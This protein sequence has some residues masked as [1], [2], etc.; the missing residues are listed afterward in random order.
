MNGLD[1]VNLFNGNLTVTVP[2]GPRYHV[3]GALSYGLTLVYSG[4]AWEFLDGYTS[5]T[6]S[7]TPG[8]NI[9]VANRRSNA[10]VGWTLS[11]GRLFPRNQYPVQESAL[12]QYETPDG[13][14]HEF[15][16]TV[17]TPGNV[18][19]DVLQWTDDGT[20]LRLKKEADGSRLVEFPD[21]TVQTFRWLDAYAP[22]TWGD[23]TGPNGSW[24]LTR[25]SDAFGNQVTI[26]YRTE[27]VYPEVWVI[28][29]GLRQQSVYFGETIAQDDRLVLDH[30]VLSA[31]GGQ[32]TQWDFSYQIRQIG[33]GN[34]QSTSTSNYTHTVSTMPLLTAITAPAAVAGAPRQTYSMLDPQG[35]PYYRVATDA[36]LSNAHLQGMQLPTKGWLEWSYKTYVFAGSSD[37]RVHRS[38]AVSERRM[39][40]RSRDAAQV[41]TW[42][43]QRVAS[44]VQRC[45]PQF[46]T[47][48]NNVTWSPP[49]QLVVAITTPEQFMTVTYFGL[50]DFDRFGDDPCQGTN[51]LRGGVY[52]V[53]Q[54]GAVTKNFN[55]SD[56][57]P[58]YLSSE[59]FAQPLSLASLATGA[60]GS[61]HSWRV[62][63]TPVRT[64]WVRYAGT[65]EAPVE[66]AH[67]T[68]YED[69]A[70]AMVACG[71]EPCYSSV[72]RYGLVAGTYRQSSSGG[73][74]H[75]ANGDSAGAFKTT[76][77]NYPD[78]VPDSAKWLLNLY[79][80]Q[81]SA[82]DSAERTS[83]VNSCADLAAS[84]LQTPN[85]NF[86]R[87]QFCRDSSTGFVSRA[88]T[89]AGGSRN[90]AVAVYTHDMGDVIREDYYGGDSQ[91]IPQSSD[92]CS[93]TLPSAPEYRIAHTYSAGALAS[94]SYLKPA[95]SSTVLQ[96]TTNVIDASSGLVRSSTDSAGVVTT[97]DY[98]LLGRPTRTAPAGTA[99]TVLT[100]QDPTATA[101]AEVTSSTGTGSSEVRAKTTFDD[102]GRVARE[103]KLMPSNSEI[104][105]TTT[106][107]GSGW[108]KSVSEWGSTHEATFGGF[109]PFGRASILT[110]AD[111][112][113]TRVTYRGDRSVEKTVSIATPAGVQDATTKEFYD[114]LHRLTRVV[115][116]EGG[117]A[118]YTYDVADHLVTVNMGQQTRAFSYDGR[119]LLR[120]ET[121]P[122]LGESGNGTVTYG[123]YDSRGHARS[124]INGTTS[125]GTYD[126]HYTFD[127]AERL[128]TVKDRGD[129]LLIAY[130]YGTAGNG[131]TS[132]IGRLIS[133]TRYNKMPGT[134][135]D[136]VVAESYSY[137]AASGRLAAKHTDV[138]SGSTT[139]QSFD[140][141]FDYDSVGS[142]THPGYPTC[143][144]PYA[145][146]VPATLPPVT[147]TYTNGALTAVGTY[148]QLGYNGNGTLGTVTHG[149]T[150]TTVDTI[151]PD[152]DGMARPLTLRYDVVECGA[153]VMP[154][155]AGPTAIC[156][157]TSGQT[158]SA[159]VP[160]VAGVSY[161][162]SV[163]DGALVSGGTGDTIV[164]RPNSGASVVSVSV[165]ETNSCTSV[166]A[167]RA[168]RIGLPPEIVRQPKGA[169][170]VTSGNQAVSVS[171]TIDAVGATLY[172]WY[173]DGVAITAPTNGLVPNGNTI[174]FTSSITGSHDVYAVAS[175]CGGATQSASATL[176]IVNCDSAASRQVMIYGGGEVWPQEHRELHVWISDRD[177]G[178]SDVT[179]EWHLGSN[180]LVV[181]NQPTYI[182]TTSTQETYY[183]IV[184][185][186]DC[187]NSAP[188]RTAPDYVW[189]HGYCGLP[190]LKMTQSPTSAAA[191][192]VTVAGVTFKAVLDWVDVS[193]QWYQ[194]QSGD[195]RS[196]IT[197]DAGAPNQLTLFEDSSHRHPPYWVRAT[198]SCGF[199]RDSE[200]I[201]FSTNGCQPIVFT[202]Q[203]QSATI[204]RGG[205]V[206]LAV[207]TPFANPPVTSYVW[208][209]NNG[210][211][212]EQINRY[213]SAMLDVS[214]DRSTRYAVTVANSCT[215]AKSAFAT[216]RVAECSSIENVVWPADHVVAPGVPTTLTVSATPAGGTLEYTWYAGELG[217]ES[218]PK[219]SSS[220]LVVQADHDATY[221]V[222]IKYTGST[223][224]YADSATIHITVCDPAHVSG[225]YTQ[226]EIP[227]HR[228]NWAYLSYP[229]LAGTSL[230][231]TWYEGQ[232]GDRHN[233][234][235]HLPDPRVSPPDTTTYW[236]EVTGV[237]GG[238]STT[239]AAT[240]PIR[241]SVCPIIR[242][243]PVAAASEMMPGATTTLT[244]DGGTS[245]AS[246]R[247]YVG[248]TGDTTQ[249]FG[250]NSATVT[251]PAMGSADTSYWVRITSGS[252]SIDSSAVTVHVCT[253]MV[254]TWASAMNINITAGGQ[255]VTL[256]VTPP[257]MSVIVSWY[258]GVPGDTA[259]S[260]LLSPPTLS[261]AQYQVTVFQTTTFW[262]RVQKGNCWTDT[263]GATVTVCIPTIGQQPV[264]TMIN[265]GATTRLTVTATP[266]AATYQWFTGDSGDMSHPIAGAT[267]SYYDAHPTSDTS[268]W[269]QV[270]GGCRTVDS[271]TAT[272]TICVPAAISSAVG[273]ASIVRGQSATL[274]VTASGSNL[275]YQWYAV[276]GANSRTAISGATAGSLTVS[277]L[278]TTQYQVD[279]TA[280]CG[281]TRTSS[282]LTVT[283]C[284]NPSI[285][286]Q[287]QSV[288]IFSGGTATLSV[289][290]SEATST[291][292][293]YQWYRG[294]S[295]DTSALIAG[296]TQS[297]YTTPALTSNTSYWVRA[298]CGACTPVDSQTA[299]VSMCPFATS[300]GSP[301]SVNLAVGQAGHLSTVTGTGYTY[302]WYVGA[303]GN[304]SSPVA[305][306][307]TSSLDLYPSGTT[308]YWCRV[309]SGTCVANTAA[310][311]MNV[312]IPTITQQPQSIMINPGTS[313]TLTAS[314]NT[315]GVTYQWYTGTSGSGTPIAGATGASVTVSPS[316]QT[317][318]WVRAIGTCNSTAD[319]ATATVSICQPPAISGFLPNQS[320]VKGQ[321]V[322][323]SISATGTNI[324]YQWYLGASG[325][326]TSPVGG[327]TG[328]SF[329]QTPADNT[330]LWVKI[331]GTCGTVNSPTITVN[332]SATPVIT[333]QPQN[334]AIYSGSATLSVTATE[335]TSNAMTYQWY[336]GAAGDTSTPVGTNA[337]T[338][339]TSTA[340]QYWVRISCGI[341]TPVNSQAA[342]VTVCPYPQSLAAPSDA[343]IAL[344]GTARL[345]APVVNAAGNTYQWYV[346]ATGNTSQPASTPSN[347]YYYDA[348]PAG[349]TSYWCRVTNGPC[350]SDSA[351]ATVRVCIPTIT[352]QPQSTTMTAGT[353][354]TLTAAANTAGVSYQWYIGTSGSTGS[355][356]S[357]ATGASLT[358]SPSSETS[359][360]VRA[361]GTCG[362][363]ADSATATVS[364]CQPAT[365]IGPLY[366]TG[367]MPGG[368]QRSIGIS[369]TGTNLTYQWYWG[370]SGDT[371]SPVTDGTGSGI[372]V[373]AWQTLRVWVR[374]TAQCGAAVNSNAAY[375]NVY[376]TITQQPPSSMTVG[377]GSTAS[378]TVAAS[379]TYLHYVW[380]WFG[381]G[382]AI[383][384]AP[385]SPSLVS[386]SI[387]SNSQVYCQVYSGDAR[388]DSSPTS[389][390]VC[391]D[392]S[393]INSISRGAGTSCMNVFA[394]TSRDYI[395]IQ[396]FQGVRGDTTHSLGSGSSIFICPTGPTPVW[397]RV[398]KPSGCYVD[399]NAL[400][401]P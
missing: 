57:T 70:S 224:C 358:V 23:A 185:V 98:D 249:P 127:E 257:D 274:Q 219:G 183:C 216:I 350:V 343:N 321:S 299:T 153:P 74:I 125:G 244:V 64:E 120:S 15:R 52:G 158:Y 46:I 223:T 226:T 320:I 41:Q 93:V 355:P 75:L 12:W 365:L 281:T 230:T 268:Y 164:F 399:S 33:S 326:T 115:E 272:V 354:T 48:P 340:G 35:Q 124:K 146:T 69:D 34:P 336:R 51:A 362:V 382:I 170:T 239:A 142:I 72:Q 348:S 3:R 77:T 251:T 264:G 280:S 304:T 210:V 177:A 2:I 213:G 309:Q 140:Q 111:G 215:E 108:T 270:N 284:T 228:Y 314:A 200:T 7:Y 318:Y 45:G 113:V 220:S 378:P 229:S 162:W 59:T 327:A 390:N 211:L 198:T 203:P 188:L 367:S 141:A 37:E 126:V 333:A 194:G 56:E 316:T 60:P 383:S 53:A 30:V 147:N 150:A 331:T 71:G 207:S 173:A 393:T 369:A 238:V 190:D 288:S 337:N 301:G 17:V 161:A 345:Y 319:S 86:L 236:A 171:A 29:D 123:S 247:W 375:I 25:I 78:V 47:D 222:R 54:S 287:P 205:A 259:H 221:W 36:S 296:A 242:Q 118:R 233:V 91:T 225:T 128:L 344:G 381:S 44:D 189:Q 137:D 38:L 18:D 110:A 275:T 351:P 361:I 84:A 186:A 169:A 83:A 106:Y 356:I 291:P 368:Y 371:S 252:C 1:N 208:E 89:I 283:V 323:S 129:H 212:P 255:S 335:S 16:P 245:S 85:T 396:W 305:N 135:A 325:V 312:C 107:T 347:G 334:V 80:D 250:G 112:A 5:A 10:G 109:D 187:T 292:V 294:A 24:R 148:A 290:V 95:D 237:C 79:T 359:Y 328:P 139:L 175:S 122:E 180:D 364:I 300:L 282:T 214:P 11:L 103:T 201:I 313:T 195:T 209:T 277:P 254:V 267:L 65:P 289:A 157:N 165:T 130:A 227:I 285:T 243:Q 102:F 286:T 232:P 329:T 352:Q 63:G 263:S 67:V 82:T 132:A 196:P 14:L 87:T 206:T 105:R 144:A 273:S 61:G 22:G 92:L 258:S 279:V 234:I 379:G 181:G 386:G 88:R 199:S 400:T 131:P 179:Y 154:I 94:T 66:Q 306:A 8:Q 184:K 217:D 218:Q 307:T 96:V 121:H 266:A 68:R 373:T 240:V 253:P 342:T 248:T 40:P 387:Y 310:G 241:V 308:S 152:P 330:Q 43:Y 302:Q 357:G 168:W 332:V 20:N 262:A 271:Q 376:P 315:A 26:S 384:G 49:D 172:T 143:A 377:Y 372:T 163:V 117:E 389:L 31:V 204:K 28:S 76:F 138:T 114:A 295:G 339:P 50:Y 338:Y 119:G 385:D 100:F 363:T 155:I 176:Q 116:P 394:D 303:S 4:N 391:Y 324:S 197:S 19:S 278:D 99:A 360:W 90:D 39:L 346:G 156:A 311:T 151:N 182:A 380:R 174:T 395:D 27:E 32:T 192:G 293:T 370:E 341:A 145:C 298:W 21:G 73:N 260:T 134:S 231:Y 202:Q 265:S 235:S 62:A 160:A 167:K 322:T 58:Y 269:V 191:N 401:V 353:S 261:H 6:S 13:G 297:S 166:T 276:N 136:V 374:V 366:S 388:V 159:S 193:F 256:A 42:T 317:S 104:S 398:I 149:G 81:C 133:S 392:Q 55:G 9:T 178:A 101:A 349:T 397:F 246:F 97:F